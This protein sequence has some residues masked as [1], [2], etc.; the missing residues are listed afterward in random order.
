MDQNIMLFIRRTSS[1]QQSNAVRVTSSTHVGPDNGAVI[2]QLNNVDKLI[3]SATSEVGL[4]LMHV[5]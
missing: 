5:L 4:L 1:V 3:K 2:A